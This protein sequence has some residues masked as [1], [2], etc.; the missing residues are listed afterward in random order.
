MLLFSLLLS[1]NCWMA[2]VQS[3]IQDCN[4][5]DIAAAVSLVLLLVLVLLLL[6]SAAFK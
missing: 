3:F 6:M 1:S 2:D 4:D 5:D